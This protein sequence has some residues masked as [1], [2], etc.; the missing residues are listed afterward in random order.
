MWDVKMN[1]P[2]ND[3]DTICLICRKEED[4][5]KYALD[6][7]VELEKGRHTIGSSNIN[8]WKQMLKIFR[9]NNNKKKLQM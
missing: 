1:Y 6:C 3:T 5:T 8:Y 9:D 7:E 2:K 4:S